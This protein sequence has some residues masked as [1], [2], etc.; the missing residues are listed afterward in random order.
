MSM[1]AGL[2]IGMAS[3]M[4]IG[5]ALSEDEPI[6]WHCKTCGHSYTKHRDGFCHA[7]LL[8]KCTCPKFQLDQSEVAKAE[9]EIEELRNTLFKYYNE[10]KGIENK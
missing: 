7:R 10:A 3:G 1:G 6:D 5:H 2:A 8:K 9:K 4:M